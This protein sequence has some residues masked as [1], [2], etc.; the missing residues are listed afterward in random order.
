MIK[1][2]GKEIINKVASIINDLDE[3]QVDTFVDEIVKSRTIF[4]IGAGRS[5]LV[6]RAFAMRLMH[7]G[8][9]VYVVGDTVT[10]SLRPGDL[11][12]AISG[13]GETASVVSSIIT[14]RE[15]KARVIA[16]TGQEESTVAK[17]AGVFVKI[18][19]V[20]RKEKKDRDY[21]ANQL[22]GATA[23][24]TPLGTVFELSSLIFCDSVIA[25]LMKIMGTT[26]SEMKRQHANIE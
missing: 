17:G 8:F 9:S 24:L 23:T 11:L 15:H 6:A 14:A 26:E 3:E 7:L 2:T 13:S 20:V 5:G 4:V 18:Q 12:V 16:I 10:P 1:K 22:S 19:T 21:T 25:E